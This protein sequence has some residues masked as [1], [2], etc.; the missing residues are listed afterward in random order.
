MESLQIHGGFTS[1]C[2]PCDYVT[3]LCD[4]S[5]RELSVPLTPREFVAMLGN[6]KRA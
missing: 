1:K 2:L 4:V 5:V 3:P 6:W